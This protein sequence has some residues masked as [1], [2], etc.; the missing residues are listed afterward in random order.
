VVWAKGALKPKKRCRMHGGLSTGPR[1]IE[2]KRRSAANIGCVY[3]E[4]SGRFRASRK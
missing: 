1:T 2:G 4:S 3:D